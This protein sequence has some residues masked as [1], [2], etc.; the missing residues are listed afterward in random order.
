MNRNLSTLLTPL[1][2]LLVAA[3]TTALTAQE[4]PIII[5]GTSQGPIRISLSGYSGEVQSVL[6][7]DLGVV[8]FDIVSPETAQ[9]NVSGSNSGAVEGQLVERATRFVMLE[10][11]RYSGGS[12]RGQA[13]ALADDIVQKLTGRPGI[14][15]TKIAFKGESGGNSEI[16]IADYDGANA[17]RVT[18]DGALVAAPCWVPGRFMLYYTSYK[19]GFPDVYSHDLRTGARN[20]V[21]KFPGLNTS[22]ALA[23]GGQRVALIL[24]KEWSPDLY[25]CD[26]DG[27]SVKRLTKTRE[28]ESSPCWSPD[29]RTICFVS[30][31]GGAPAMYTISADGSNM[32]RLRVVGVRSM[33]EPDWSPDGTQIVFTAMRGEF[34]ICV[35]PAQGGEAKTLAAGSDPSWAPNSRTVVFTRKQRGKQVLSLL[36]VP[37]KRI[38]DVAQNL[39][40]CSQPS[41]AK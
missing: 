37:T 39:G 24:S 35:V 21:A 16:Y 5:E 38:K 19:S 18:M 6:K 30:R 8:G 15:R 9:F 29:G 4:T 27:G 10:N 1:A 23:P 28:D 2:Y 7:N 12:L 41:W 26:S 36:D 33:S 20:V 40:N 11:R 25:V 32:K 3:I 31:Q 22:A 17:T 14:A 13:H 34:E